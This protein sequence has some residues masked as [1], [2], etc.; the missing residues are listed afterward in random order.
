M[1]SFGLSKRSIRSKERARTC[2]DYVISR[3]INT[4]LK[5]A[6]FGKSC[7]N[8]DTRKMLRSVLKNIFWLYRRLGFRGNIKYFKKKEL[9]QPW[10]ALTLQLSL[11]LFFKALFAS[12]MP[13]HILEKFQI[14]TITSSKISQQLQLMGQLATR[15]KQIV[16]SRCQLL[17]YRLISWLRVYSHQWINKDCLQTR[18][19]KVD[20]RLITFF[21]FFL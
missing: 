16:C 8:V 12:F 9:H 19:V 14:N 10:S 13:R 11:S 17:C 6:V 20:V 7:W 1:F 18:N 21:F 2:K 3:E 15:G 4:V 5:M